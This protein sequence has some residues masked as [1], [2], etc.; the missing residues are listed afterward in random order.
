M[1]RYLP[2]NER[3]TLN[4]LGINPKKL[5]IEMNDAIVRTL[6][7]STLT[8]IRNAFVR[9]ALITENGWPYIDV[10]QLKHLLRT[11]NSGAESPLWQ[12][13]ID[14]LV[15]PSLPFT[16]EKKIYITGSDFIALLDARIRLSTGQTK[17]YLRYARD[18][19][20]SILSAD[21]IQD[22]SASFNSRIDQDRSGLKK[23]RIDYYQ[24]TFCEFTGSS[25]T[26]YIDVEFAHIDSV[27]TAPLRANDI[28]NGVIILKE[29]HAE[30]TRRNIHDFEGMYDFCEE[31]GYYTDWADDFV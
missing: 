7:A 3:Y 30:L 22:L 18:I 8:T 15:S 5:T 11:S 28:H 31:M 19:Y 6:T 17:L 14:G 29:I 24:I 23:R 1:T 12:N 27:A 20:N 13:G 10:S 4:D 26:S 9:G 16:V 2:S 25:F 21:P